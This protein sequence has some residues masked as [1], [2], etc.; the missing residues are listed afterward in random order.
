MDDNSTNKRKPWSSPPRGPP[1]A[2]TH[3]DAHTPKGN[4]KKAR[5]R[6][7]PTRCVCCDEECDKQMAR[8]KML[9]ADMH[10]YFNIPEPP[11]PVKEDRKT[12]LKRSEIQNRTDQQKKHDCFMDALGPDAKQRVERYLSS[13]DKNVDESEV[14]SPKSKQEFASIHVHPEILKLVTKTS[15][16]RRT[17]PKSIPRALGRKLDNEGLCSFKKKDEVPS[18]TTNDYFPLPNYTVERAKEY[19]DLLEKEL[20]IKEREETLHTTSMTPAVTRSG[21]AVSSNPL[22]YEM[23][24]LRREMQ[25]R[26]IHLQARE[27]ELEEREKK[28]KQSEK[29]IKNMFMKRE[30]TFLEK[31]KKLQAK[32]KAANELLE[33][34]GGLSR[35]TF[36]NKDWHKNNDTSATSLFGFSTWKETVCYVHALFGLYPPVELPKHDDSIT[37]FEWCL[38]AKIRINCGMPYRTIGYILGLKAVDSYVGEKIKPWVHKWGEAGEDLSILNIT[39]EFLD[40]TCP[41][42]YKDENLEQ[43]CGIPDGKDFKIFTPRK[44]TLFTR[45]CF[46]DKVHASA[47]RGIS[48]C[49]PMGLSYEHTHLFLARVSEKALVELWGPRLKKCPKGY[50]MLS[51]RGFWDTARFYPNMNRQMTPKFL[52]GR[53]QFTAEEVSSD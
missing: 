22:S 45:A 17:L 53:A 34:I 30:R 52:S 18:S 28:C 4:R 49:T 31:E 35:L 23:D 48:W 5:K 7:E 1:P 51:D 27:K 12:K 14:Y 20:I 3:A 33:N 16:G 6:K 10:V 21:M 19:I 36:T 32:L 46:S 47:V 38:A 26:E 44:N 41:Q 43:I 13:D 2:T 15:N 25:E 29:S 40:A 50:A 9:N 42:A 39:P 8:L 37:Q 11:K 24:R